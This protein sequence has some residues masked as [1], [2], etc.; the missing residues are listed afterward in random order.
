MVKTCTENYYGYS[1]RSCNHT[2]DSLKMAFTSSRLT[3]ACSKLGGLYPFLNQ[4]FSMT[5]EIVIRCLIVIVI[6]AESQQ[7]HEKNNQA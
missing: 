6:G 5:S 4:S 7:M 2:P 1:N 3:T